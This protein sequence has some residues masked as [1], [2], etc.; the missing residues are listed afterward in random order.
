MQ[1]IINLI[2]VLCL[3][4]AGANANPIDKAISKSNVNKS[5]VSVSV[6][7][8]NTGKI[9]Y[10]HNSKKPMIPASTLKAVTY[11]T[12]LKEL[13]NDYEFKTSLYKTT[14]N[15]LILKLGA[16]PFLEGSDLRR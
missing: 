11:V 8:T 14:D 6:K 10:E 7:D 2:L 3:S 5:A 4:I 15:E 12:A 9:L 13:G 16:D 1:K